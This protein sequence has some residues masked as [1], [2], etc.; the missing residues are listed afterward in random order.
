MANA[1]QL[2]RLI[3]HLSLDVVAGAMVG[4]LFF[5]R[6][7]S[8][9]LT[10]YGLIALGLTVW[11]IYTTDHLR[12]AK[13]M[14]QQASTERH[15]FHQQ[16][17]TTLLSVVGVAM[18]LDAIILFFIRRQVLESGVLLGL[19][20]AVYLI[21]QRS[22]KFLKEIF[23]AILYTCG[24]LLPSVSVTKVG[25]TATH[26]ILIFQFAI[27]ALINLFMFSWFDREVD[28]QDKQY[29]FVTIVGERTTRCSIWF[30]LLMETLLTLIQCV[31]SELKI[32]ALCLGMMGLMLWMIFVFRTSLAKDDY[33]RFFGDGVFLFPGVYLLC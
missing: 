16:H 3:N 23:I 8:V 14:D 21:T 17:F 22:L 7:F 27:L 26:Y 18:I 9:G 33:Y 24:V 29:S 12:D 11:I 1:I 19:A 5:A 15:R 2:Y 13:G 10:P 30:L 25:L 32:P 6:I 31:Y 28:Q 4:A 20:V